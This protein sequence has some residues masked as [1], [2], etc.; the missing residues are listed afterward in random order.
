MNNNTVDIRLV[1]VDRNGMTIRE[2][3][4]F[5]ADLDGPLLRASLGPR[6]TLDWIPSRKALRGLIDM[7]LYGS[8]GTAFLSIALATEQEGYRPVNVYEPGFGAEL[9][10]FFEFCRELWLSRRA[11]API[12]SHVK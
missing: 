10:G 8:F 6:D 1:T 9:E 7:Y 3:L 12:T 11:L 2:L 4:R 5:G